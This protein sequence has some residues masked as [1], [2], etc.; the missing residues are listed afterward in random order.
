[1]KLQAQL[2]GIENGVLVMTAPRQQVLSSRQSAT[3]QQH[4]QQPTT[5]FCAD[6]EALIDY[7][8]E[9]YHGAQS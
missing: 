5:K 7:I 9:L 4:Q 1:M 8:R 2:S 6:E 3:E